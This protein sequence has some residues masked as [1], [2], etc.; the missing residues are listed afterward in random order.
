M[1]VQEV[2][3]VVLP[4]PILMVVAVVGELEEL[5]FQVLTDLDLVV[6]VCYFQYLEHL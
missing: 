4:R 1:E 2:P 3:E 5:V 6:M